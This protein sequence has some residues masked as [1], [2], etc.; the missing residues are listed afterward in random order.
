MADA[1][2][3]RC[4]VAI[5]G[6]GPVGQALA[7]LLGQRGWRV[8]VLEKQTAPYPLPR[9]VHFDHEVG[10]ILQACGVADELRGRTEPADVYEWRNAAGATLLRFESKAA[11]LSGWPEA[12]MFAQPDLERVLDTRAR[13]LATVDVRRGADVVGIT[14][15]ADD[16]ALRIATRGTTEQLLARWVIGCDGANSFVRPHLGATV[17]DLGF[18]FDWLIVD[19]LPHVATPWSPVNVQVCD[20]ARPTTLVS[21]GPGRRRWEFMRLPGEDLDELNSEAA[22]WRLLAPWNVTPENTRLER[23]T[24]SRFQARWVDGWRRGRL[25][26]AGDAAHQMP[27]FAGQGMCSGLRD[28]ANLAWKLDLVLAGRAADGLLDTYATERVPHVAAVIDFSMALGRVICIADPAEAAA[29]DEVMVAAAASGAET[30]PPPPLAIGAGVLRD[31]DP[32]AGRLFLQGRVEHA[33]RAGLFDD[34]VGRGFVLL[35]TVAD[36]REALAP[37]TARWLA[38]VGGITAHVGADAP[39]HD[40]DGAYVRWFAAAGVA[41]VLQRPDGYVYGTA[42]ALDGAEALVGALRATLAGEHVRLP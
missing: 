22:A 41:V 17:T 32:Q 40:V 7:I 34:V 19:V 14:A 28:A 24:V 18:F 33:G 42:A 20:P 11:G 35:S 3:A 2:T 25:V 23:H 21:G 13:A 12:N 30:T 1:G 6:Y 8:T 9:A 27:P 39:I 16:V 29:R 4:D 37:D 31:G 38:A 10:R 5:V 36:P 15:G 26:L